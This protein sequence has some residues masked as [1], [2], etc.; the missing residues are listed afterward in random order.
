MN[1]DHY[2]IIVDLLNVNFISSS[3]MLNIVKH[4]HKL[5][6]QNKGE[7]VFLHVPE[8]VNQSYEVAGFNTIFKF[9]QDFDSAKIDFSR[10]N[11]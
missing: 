7:S 6:R 1:D 4:Q 8:L 10:S 5:I 2:N 11:K 9:F 3:G